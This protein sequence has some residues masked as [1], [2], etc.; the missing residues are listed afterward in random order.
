VLVQKGHNHLSQFNSYVKLQPSYKLAGFVQFSSMWNTNKT[1]YFLLKK[2]FLLEVL[3]TNM[4]YKHFWVSD[5]YLPMT[6]AKQAL[7]RHCLFFPYPLTIYLFT[8]PLCLRS[9]LCVFFLWG[10]FVFPQELQP[11]VAWQR[12]IIQRLKRCNF[13]CILIHIHHH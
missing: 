7:L 5:K 6:S 2:H 3:V 10:L 11:F 1:F 8:L 4:G 13:S 9:L 12:V